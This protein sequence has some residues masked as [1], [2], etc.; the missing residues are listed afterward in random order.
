METSPGSQQKGK[1]SRSRRL[2]FAG[3]VTI[4]LVATMELASFGIG[5]ALQDKWSMYRRPVPNIKQTRTYDEYMARRDPVAGWPSPE[6]M[7]S[8][9]FDPT[10]ARPSPAF[11]YSPDNPARVALYGD[12]FTASPN[13]DEEAWGN[14]LA[15]LLGCRVANY[16]GR[17]YGSD[18][19]FVKFRANQADTAKFV[20]LGH[21]SEDIVRNLCRNRDLLTYSQWYAYKPRF[22]L[23]SDG[24]LE[25]I[26]TPALTEEEH[27]RFLGLADPPL[28][29]EHESFAPGGPAGVVDL[30]FPFTVAVARNCF[31]YLMRA[32][33]AGEPTYA[34]FYEPGHPLQGMEITAAICETFTEE[35]KARGMQPIVLLLPTREDIEDG[36]EKNVWHYASL[37]EELGR[38][39]VEFLDFGPH[40]AAHIGDRPLDEFYDD[41]SHFKP[42][43]DALLAQFIADY[44]ER[45]GIS[46]GF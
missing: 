23:D 9:M 43:S 1:R 7:G 31:G 18:Q 32:R 12:S 38:R 17:G 3:V 13:S 5:K 42:N 39:G 34:Q 46:L 45:A 8:Y 40:L 36:R 44:V 10:G 20:V 25:L 30:T 11:P 33:F 6:E 16:G 21:L 24:E 26:P 41:T 27:L 28:L 29:L 15:R 37:L 19:A 2:A 14:V 35:A 4:V 22:I